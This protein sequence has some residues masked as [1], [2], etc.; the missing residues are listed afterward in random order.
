M[1]RIL[2]SQHEDPS[3]DDYFVIDGK[4]ESNNLSYKS[5]E[6]FEIVNNSKGW[7]SIK[8]DNLLEIF[9]KGNSFA[10][11]SYYENYDEAGRKLFFVFY[12]KGENLESALE[13][14]KIDSNLINRN[15]SYKSSVVNLKTTNKKIIYL[16]FISIIV[17][18][19]WLF[20]I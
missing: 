5:I 18:I 15:F 19:I 1:K 10:I 20:L 2:Y 11:K 16:I 7:K 6:A 9:K 17:L 12:C 3:K 13:F 8:N 4:I 14:L